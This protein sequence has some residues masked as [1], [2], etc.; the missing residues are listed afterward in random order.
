MWGQGSR[1][2]CPLPGR[3]SQALVSCSAL[4]FLPQSTSPPVA[5]YHLQRALPGGIVLMELAFQ[6][7]G[8]GPRPAVLTLLHGAVLGWGR[9][10]LWHG[11]QVPSLPLA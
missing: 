2:P 8:K 10:P 7:W 6:V 4:L 3:L 11:L 1:H 5:T 9:W